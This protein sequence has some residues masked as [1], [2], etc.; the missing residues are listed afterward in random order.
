MTGHLTPEQRDRYSNLAMTPDELLA[1]GEHLARC[2]RC[3]D[4]IAASLPIIE[5]IADVQADLA[6]AASAPAHLPFEILVRFLEDRLGSAD[7]EIVSSHL[8]L[9]TTCAA[10][11]DDLRRFSAEMAVSP[12][13]TFSPVTQTGLFRRFRSWQGHLRPGP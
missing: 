2:P 4:E 1:A 12:R 8:L 9:C 6:D 5:Q 11:L 3:R 10:E 7:L 13:Q